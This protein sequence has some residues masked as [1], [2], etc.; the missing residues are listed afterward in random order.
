MTSSYSFRYIVATLAEKYQVI[1][2]DLPGAG[3][4]EAPVDL[5]LSPRSMAQ[6]IF[7]LISALQVEPPYI[8][9][10]SLGGYVSLWFAVLFPDQVRKLI[11]MHAPGFPQLRLSAMQFLL[12]F[13]GGRALVRRIMC[14]DPDGF[15]ASNI[16]YYDPSLM[17]REEAREYG[18]IFRDRDRTEVFIRILR[19]SLDPSAMRELEERLSEIRDSKRMLA[20]VRLFWAREDVMVPPNFGLKYQELLPMAELVWFDQASHFLQVDDPERTVKEIMRFAI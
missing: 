12:N 6:F 4:S 16:H 2:P 5:S 15:A 17:S 8:V 7:C 19:E 9:G 18:A 10:N 3:R 20:P 14:R 1:V 13:H 11:V